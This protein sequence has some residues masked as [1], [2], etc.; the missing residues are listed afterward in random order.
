MNSPL[1]GIKVLDMSRTLAGP[2]CSMMLGDNGADVIKVEQPEVGDESRRFVPPTWNGESS[3]Y[4]SSN[5]N[6]R[7]IT[8]NLKNKKAKD[9]IYELVKKSDVIIENFRTGTMEKLGFGYETLREINP[10]IIYCSI[11]GFGRTGPMKDKPG[12]DILMQG[13]GGIMGTTGEEDGEPVKAGPS[14]VDLTTGMFA[15]IAI[16]NAILAREKNDEGQFIDVS[17]LDGQVALMNYLITGYL[18]TGETPKKMGNAHPSVVPYQ[19]FQTKDKPVIIA[20]ANDN[21]FFKICDALGWEDIK[22]NQKYQTNALRVINRSELIQ[23]MKMRVEQYTSDELIKIL[24]DVDV[25]VG[26]INTI[27]TIA[28][29]EQV[30]HRDM[31]PKVPHPNIQDL[32]VPGIPYKLSKTPSTIRRHPPLLGE[33]T[34]E[35]LIELG[36]SENQIKQLKQLKVI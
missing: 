29:D 28:K 26:P 25:P 5:R 27:D 36:Y 8:L 12:Y 34:N 21:L 6:K 10:S 7:S 24:T 20:A 2:F 33:H 11:S 3:Y 9:I 19:A 32:R 14:F 23:E 13:Y 30:I 35:I 16:L 22:T 15:N 1:E 18:A 31:L 17:L 4:L